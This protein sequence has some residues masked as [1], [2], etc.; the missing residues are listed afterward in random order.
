MFVPSINEGFRQ[1]W[2]GWDDIGTFLTMH[3]Y[4]AEKI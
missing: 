3:C 2:K 1:L 4:S